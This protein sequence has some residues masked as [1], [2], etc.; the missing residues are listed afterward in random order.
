MVDVE[1]IKNRLQSYTADALEFN[2]PHFSHQL[3]LRGGSMAMVVSNLLNPT[4]LIGVHEEL[5]KYGD[6]K[7]T[8]FFKMTAQQTMILPVIFDRNT[9]KSLYIITFI[10]RYRR[11][12]L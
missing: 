7:H 4:Q 10:I 6:M 3:L 11:V 12:L 5:G 8:L 2:E 9:K 1:S